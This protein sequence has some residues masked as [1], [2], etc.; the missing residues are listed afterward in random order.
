MTPCPSFPPVPTARQI[1]AVPLLADIVLTTLSSLTLLIAPRVLIDLHTHARPDPLCLHLARHLGILLLTLSLPS[2]LH[3]LSTPHPTTDRR[4]HHIFRTRHAMLTLLH[5]IYACA[6]YLDVRAHI[7][8]TLAIPAAFLTL[9]SS[10]GPSL[11]APF[12]SSPSSTPSSSSSSSSSLH[13]ARFHLRVPIALDGALLVVLS[14]TL[15]AFPAAVLRVLYHRVSPNALSVVLA[16]AIAAVLS[17]ASAQSAAAADGTGAR[18]S[19]VAT[20][21]V[22]RVAAGV[23]MLTIA[24][25]DVARARI[26]F[27]LE[28]A[29]VIGMAIVF[30]VVNSA[31][32]WW[33]AGFVARHLEEGAVVISNDAPRGNPDVPTQRADKVA[34]QKEA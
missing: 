8:R 21:H 10:G 31:A 27:Q 22:A 23:G 6:H 5:L 28:G 9:L 7:L 24:V 33:L 13:S 1:R 15:F 11:S 32:A 17:A 14:T 25:V 18:V 12:S 3:L 16:R 29:V 34:A 30:A 26:S 4:A 20:L 2:T 19:A